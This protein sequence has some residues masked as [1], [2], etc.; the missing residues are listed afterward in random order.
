M[1]DN[2]IRF[3]SASR[4][5]SSGSFAQQDSAKKK[6]DLQQEEKVKKQNSDHCRNHT[7]PKKLKMKMYR[8]PPPNL[9]QDDLD[10]ISR[11]IELERV[12]QQQSVQILFPLFFPLNPKGHAMIS[13]FLKIAHAWV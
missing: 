11:S 2:V 6:V 3:P 13:L 12:D 5:K 7:E 10:R 9:T 4:Q 1:S 8:V